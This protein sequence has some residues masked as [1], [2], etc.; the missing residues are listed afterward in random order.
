MASRELVIDACCTI[1]LLATGREVEIV[2]ALEVCLLDTPY[3]SG[4]PTAVWSRPDHEGR[5]VR[6]PASTAALRSC[7]LLVTRSLDTEALHDAFALAS[8][9]IRGADASCVAL[10]GVLGLP[11]ATD[12]HKQ[13]LIARELFPGITLTSTLEVVHDAGLAL[14]WDDD[15]LAA[16]A[17]E[18]RWRG[19]FAPPRQDPRAAWYT[20]LL[21]RAGAHA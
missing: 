12:D 13:Q 2:K 19:N 9:R 20:A 11:L 3:T 4:E 15:Q 10:A 17:A 21:R 6:E 5:R 8:Q 7:G 18:L 1:N 16:I 14:G